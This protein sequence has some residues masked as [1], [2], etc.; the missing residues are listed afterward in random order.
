MADE[1]IPRMTTRQKLARFGSWV[2]LAWPL[3]ASITISGLAFAQTQGGA[4][5]PGVHLTP[6]VLGVFIGIVAVVGPMFWWA[7]KY[8]NRVTALERELSRIIEHRDE[9][10]T[11]NSAAMDRIAVAAE[12]MADDGP[13]RGC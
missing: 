8:D 1:G 7:G 13:P 11:R 4:E 10:E 3:V 5:G 2:A 9:V 6:G 12:R